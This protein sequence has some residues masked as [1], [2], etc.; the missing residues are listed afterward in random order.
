MERETE[1]ERDGG[2]WEKERGLKGQWR[3]GAKARGSV[4][5]AE[6]GREAENTGIFAYSG[7]GC[8]RKGQSSPSGAWAGGPRAQAGAGGAGEPQEEETQHCS[9][10]MG[11]GGGRHKW[12]FQPTSTPL[13]GL[14]LPCPP[15]QQ[16]RLICTPTRQS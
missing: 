6:A 3:L 7:K 11:L 9:V 10:V 16:H 1:T 12:E 2:V 14:R 8:W 13:C 4:T 5:A 15:E